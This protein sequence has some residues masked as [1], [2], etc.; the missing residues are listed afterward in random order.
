MRTDFASCKLRRSLLVWLKQ[1]AARRGVPIYE[2][3]EELIAR[4]QVRPWTGKE[5][6]DA[7]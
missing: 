5:K 4:G 1:Q 7:V 3:V 2:L 6:H